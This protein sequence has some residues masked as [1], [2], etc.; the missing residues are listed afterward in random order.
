MASEAKEIKRRFKRAIYVSLSI[1]Q[2]LAEDCISVTSVLSSMQVCHCH[3]ETISKKV[4]VPAVM[5][6]LHML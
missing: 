2:F 6:L 3:L 5:V 1:L 4:D